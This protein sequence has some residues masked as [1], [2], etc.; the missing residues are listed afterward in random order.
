VVQEEARVLKLMKWG[1]VP[2]WAKDTSTGYKMINARAET[3]A[4]KPSFKK[5]LKHKRCLVVADSFYEWR[6]V[7]GGRTKIPM[8]FV[9]KSREPFAFAGLWDTWQNP[10]GGELRSFTIIT[11]GANAVLQPIHDRMPVILRQQDED[12]WLDPDLK[13]VDKLVP[14]LIPYSSEEMEGY[15]VSTLVNSPKNDTPACILEGGSP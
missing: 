2:S 4:Q 10:E 12:L 9:F 7:N 14:L 15:E 11:T 8:R 1:L 3:V 13:D 5:S 6:K